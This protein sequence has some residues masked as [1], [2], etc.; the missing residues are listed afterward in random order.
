MTLQEPA[1][2]GFE[3]L[4]PIVQ[5]HVVNALG[6][7][8]LRPLQEESIGPILRGDDALLLAPTAGGK[9]EAALFPLL[10]RMSSEK[11]H[12]TSVLYLCPLKALLNNVQVRAEIYTGWLGRTSALRHSD[13][14]AAARRRQLLDRPDILLTTPESIES[15]LV[16]AVYNPEVIFKDVRA[17][18]VDEVHAFAGDDRGWHLLAV[19]ERVS[20]L[21]G[22]PIQRIGCSATVGNAPELLTWL[23]GSNRQ[24]GTAA[25]VIAP[26]V[27]TTAADTAVGLDYVGSVPNA[28]LVAAQLHRGEKRLIFADSRGLVEQMASELRDHETTTFV[29]HSSLSLDER[30][31]AEAAFSEA[32]D[33]VIVSTSTLELG[34]DV[35]DLDRVIQLGS[36]TT[37]A[38]FLQRLGRTGRRPGTVRNTLFLTTNDEH[39]L[40]A[41]GLLLLWSEG[42]VEPV[43]APARPLHVVVQ[44]VLAQALQRH[45]TTREDFWEPLSQLGIV[46]REELDEIVTHLH[47]IGLLDHDHGLYFIGP[48]TERLFGRRHFLELLTVFLAPPEINVWHGRDV[49]GSVDPIFLL[50][51]RELEGPSVLTLGGRSWKVTQIDWHRHRVF[52]VPSDLRG[53]S[54]WSGSSTILSAQLSDAM[55]RVLLGAEPTGIDMSKR[56]RQRLDHL[57]RERAPHVDGDNPILVLDGAKMIWWTWAGLRNN[58]RQLA[59]LRETSPELLLDVGA[60]DNH[61][62]VLHPDRTAWDVEAALR[63]GRNRFGP[64]LSGVRVPITA[65]AITGLK[66][67]DLLPH[68]LIE[69]VINTR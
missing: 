60:C 41:A 9:T 65:E 10:T 46:T 33:C 28:A 39:F 16:S 53:R 8:A 64:D 31:R 27:S 17:V 11:W 21:A 67:V 35:G 57:R 56:A 54:R 38:S 66:F 14:S 43:H 22:R 13:I 32:R 12:G 5:H 58:L 29:S 15:M 61:S 55:R 4:D 40:R 20:C 36:S 7:S 49:I 52:V 2:A 42:Y 48:E 25:T 30:R 24:A 23:Q 37:V 59:A 34:I 62:I 45:E 68:H 44:Q 63:E 26:A 18:I 51:Q 47:D 19:L 3:A 1:T 6:W 50:K 69:D